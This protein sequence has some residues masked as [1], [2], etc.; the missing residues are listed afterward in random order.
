MPAV[1]SECRKY[2]NY[3]YIWMDPKRLFYYPKLRGVEVQFANVWH[4]K[5]GWL[6]KYFLC[7]ASLGRSPQICTVCNS[8]TLK[9]QKL[10]PLSKIKNDKS[11]TSICTKDDEKHYGSPPRLLLQG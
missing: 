10:N 3:P 9:N 7:L 4:F 5:W 11:P 1:I 8:V 2:P 6:G